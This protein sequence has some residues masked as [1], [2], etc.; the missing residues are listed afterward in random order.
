M[1]KVE[2]LLEVRVRKVGKMREEMEKVE[3]AVEKLGGASASA[4]GASPTA[5]CSQL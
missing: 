5:L 2:K 4:V 1:K 3:K